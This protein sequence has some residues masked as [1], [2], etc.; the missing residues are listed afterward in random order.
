MP[1]ASSE[2]LASIRAKAQESL[3]HL[4]TLSPDEKAA[5]RENRKKEKAAAARK[6]YHERKAAKAAA[7]ESESSA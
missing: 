3:R 4:A 2:M 7:A 5:W 6:R 1:P